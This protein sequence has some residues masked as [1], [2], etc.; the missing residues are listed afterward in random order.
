MNRKTSKPSSSFVSNV[1]KLTSASAVAQGLG[2]LVM[3]ILT[4]IFAPE[5]FGI[6]A[7]FASI[8][9]IITINACL[10]YE[11][12]IMLPKTDEEAANLLGLSVLFVVI[13]SAITALTLFSAGNSIVRLLNSPELKKYLGLLPLSV[14]V[15]G[16]LLALNYWN[17][18]TKHFGRLSVARVISAFVAQP[19]KLAAG[20]AGYVSGGIL[21]ATT[22]LGDLVS[23]S[24]LAVQIWRDG[25]RLFKRN[26]RWR[27]MIAGMKRH[28]KFPVFDTWSALLNAVSSHL[29]TVLLAFFFSP[30][31]VG[32]YALGTSLI[33][34]PINLI[35]SAIFQVFFQRASE[36]NITGELGYIVENVFKR[37][38]RFGLFPLL[39]LTVI[40]QD[41]F[42]IAFGTRWA[43]AGFYVQLLSPWMFFVFLAS[44]LSSLFEVLEQQRL[45][46]FCNIVLLTSRLISLLIGGYMGSARTALLL[47]SISGILIYAWYS[48]L[49]L[50]LSG[51]SWTRGLRFLLQHCLYSGLGII[52]IVFFRLFFISATMSIVFSILLSLIYEGIAAAKDPELS[53]EI[54]P[55]LSRLRKKSWV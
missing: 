34:L 48:F 38:V 37:L 55:F 20:L 6:A 12:S 30:V 3:P 53:I 17:S 35:G 40:G 47:F 43:E 46:L 42:V 9:G 31:I 28:K 33:R 11:L 51:T 18:R 1:L 7:L 44:P 50:H 2:I 29:P 54:L 13:V 32:Y 10:R 14:F 19:T 24:F 25:H 22:I 5:A 41:L 27:N 8:A 23:T 39:I 36:A 45:A 52:V 15:S 26:V 49:I 21:I 16:L 4:R